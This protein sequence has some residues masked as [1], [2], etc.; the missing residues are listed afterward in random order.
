M[1]DISSK[2]EKGEVAIRWLVDLEEDGIKALIAAFPNVVLVGFSH[3]CESHEVT[4]D[5]VMIA[6]SRMGSILTKWLT[7]ALRGT[8]I[9]I[10]MLDFNDVRITS[11][12]EGI[13]RFFRP[14]NAY[15]LHV[16]AEK[17]HIRYGDSDIDLTPTEF[18]VF[19]L[20]RDYGG[21]IVSRHQIIDKIWGTEQCAT[22]NALSIHVSRINQKFMESAGARPV[23]CV[24]RRGYRL[25][26]DIDSVNQV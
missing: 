9:P 24:R 11:V 4:F 26:R 13:K 17:H 23:E 3:D 25:S 6:P 14:D 10:F 22:D 16:E 8:A 20:I 18:D 19:L 21:R 12:I 15:G 1:S 2:H 5:A 7:D